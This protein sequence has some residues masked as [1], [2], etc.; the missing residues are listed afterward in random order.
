MRLCPAP[1]SEVGAGPEK[2]LDESLRASVYEKAAPN[3]QHA[4][5]LLTAH[6][7]LC[8]IT[9]QLRCLL[10]VLSACGTRGTGGRIMDR[11]SEH[12]TKLHITTALEQRATRIALL[13]VERICH[14]V[15]RRQ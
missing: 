6:F 13:I 12:L 2:R 7:R 4:A 1:L 11:P 9:E 14:G 3:Q 5:H 10:G 8:G 15:D